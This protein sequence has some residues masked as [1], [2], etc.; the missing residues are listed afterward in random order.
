MGQYN[1]IGADPPMVYAFRGSDVHG[2][3]TEE[4]AERVYVS[5]IGL[6][7]PAFDVYRETPESSPQLLLGHPADTAVYM[8]PFDPGTPVAPR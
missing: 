3:L 4:D 5:E 6:Q 2:E 1:G 7:F 8:L